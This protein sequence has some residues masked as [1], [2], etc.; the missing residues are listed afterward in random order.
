MLLDVAFPKSLVT[1]PHLF[2]RSNEDVADEFLKISDIDDV[3]NGIVLFKPLKYAFDHFH[4]SFVRD[5]T[6]D[7][8]LKLFDPNIRNTRL[9]DM[10]I[11]S[12]RN[13]KVLDA[14]HI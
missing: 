12:S 4:I 2:R 7:F 1:A 13:K 14:T 5:N 3:K 11:D 10:V 6:G 8:C 9:T